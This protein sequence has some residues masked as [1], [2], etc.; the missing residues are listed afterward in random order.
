MFRC[1]VFCCAVFAAGPAWVAEEA[2]GVFK[3]YLP[4][5]ILEMSEQEL[6][7]SVPVDLVAAAHLA[8]SEVGDFMLQF[9]L[10]TL[11]YSGLA[12]YLSAKKAFQADQGEETTGELTVG[13]IH[14]LVACASRVNL[15]KVSFLFPSGGTMVGDWAEVKGTLEII[16][17]QN[18]YPLNH[19]D[20]ECRRDRGTCEYRQIVLMLPDEGSWSEGYSIAETVDATYRITRWEKAQI[21]AVPLDDSACRTNQLS[22]NFETN[23]FFEI[24]R[25]NTP[26]DCEL[27]GIT[28]PR[29]EKPRVS[30]IVDGFDIFYEEFKRIRG[31]ASGCFS[32][33]ARKRLADVLQPD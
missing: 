30:R 29:L 11:M 17:E 7:Q 27:L 25:N 26:A 13:Q 19:V 23:E 32:S 3:D 21:D 8:N 22:F 4:L 24:A 20:I 9:Y 16:D 6:S 1:L 2:V 12:D 18:A 33:T 31:E 14:T 5:Q 10:N 28:L 15:T